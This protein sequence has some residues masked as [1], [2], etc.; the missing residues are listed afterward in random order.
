MNSSEVFKALRVSDVVQGELEQ[1]MFSHFGRRQGWQKRARF[2]HE[3]DKPALEVRYSKA[4]RIMSFVALDHLKEDDIEKL[5]ASVNDELIKERPWKI[6]RRVLF[7]HV[8]FKGAF[9]HGDHFQVLP[10]PPDAPLPPH[11]HT[12]KNPF[13]L[14]CRFRSSE[15]GMLNASRHTAMERRWAG[16]IN[17]LCTFPISL[18]NFNVSF[19]WFH[20]PPEDHSSHIGQ[21]GYHY[22]NLKVIAD[23]YSPTDGLP[24]LP[25][26]NRDAYYARFNYGEG[27]TFDLSDDFETSLAQYNSLTPEEVSKFSR[28][29]HWFRHAQSIWFQSN[30]AAQVALVCAVEALA[31]NAPDLRP[32]QRFKKTLEVLAPGLEGDNEEFYR[33][34]SKLAHGHSLLDHEIN[35][36]TMGHAG[37]TEQ[38]QL[39]RLRDVVRI[40]L[41]HWLIPD[42]RHKLNS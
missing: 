2:S 5:T 7:A 35:G 9:R 15:N 20:G 36:F 37:T 18:P 23:T 3:E 13:L 28:A 24:P 21:V 30:S 4:G 25:R 6:I 1:L 17:G 29:C 10:M 40:A 33:V 12:Q 27:Q 32:T 19:E 14:E 31:G 11:A 41:Y 38:T 34:R 16:L 39:S 42:F 26:L 8:P 22:S